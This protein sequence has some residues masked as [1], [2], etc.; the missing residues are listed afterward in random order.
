MRIY[1]LNVGTEHASI[2]DRES[3]TL[4]RTKEESTT[5]SCTYANQV[6]IIGMGFHEAPFHASSARR[7]SMEEN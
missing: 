7:L 5:L 1:G 6:V 3:S 2:L 4:Y